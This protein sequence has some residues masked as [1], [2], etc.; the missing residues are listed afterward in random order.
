MLMRLT[1]VVVTSM[2]A[3]FGA[4]ARRNCEHE[5]AWSLAMIDSLLDRASALIVL[6]LLDFYI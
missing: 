4:C 3:G 2:V 5:I 6:T 1:C